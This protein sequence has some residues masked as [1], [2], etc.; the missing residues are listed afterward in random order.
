MPDESVKSQPAD[1]SGKNDLYSRKITRNGQPDSE[2]RG[3][4]SA[5]YRQPPPVIDV[6]LGYRDQAITIDDAKVLVAHLQAAIE[7]AEEALHKV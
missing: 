6:N 3:R 5:R 7:R 2:R 4:V 1:E